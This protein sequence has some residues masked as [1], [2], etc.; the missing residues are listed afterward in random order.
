MLIEVNMF[1][2]SKK[3]NKCN[4]R[5]EPNKVPINQIEFKKQAKTQ[6]QVN[7]GFSE[8]ST[9]NLIIALKLFAD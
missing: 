1:C 4:F 9:T 8:Q 2:C 5:K 3:T 6:H 7:F